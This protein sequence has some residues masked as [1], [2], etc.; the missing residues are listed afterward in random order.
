[1]SAGRQETAAKIF[2]IFINPEQY[3][4][5]LTGA[6]LNIQLPS[7]AVDCKSV[8][9]ETINRFLERTDPDRGFRLVSL[10]FKW[11]AVDFAEIIPQFLSSECFHGRGIRWN[12]DFY[13]FECADL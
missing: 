7:V 6:A 4:T 2:Q 3:S 5:S 1:M 8:I 11:N 12:G 10:H 9:S 13:R